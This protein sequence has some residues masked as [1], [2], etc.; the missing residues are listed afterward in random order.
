[1]P[2]N[3]T[4]FSRDGFGPPQFGFHVVPTRALSM[5]LQMDPFPKVLTACAPP[6]YGKTVMLSSL[7]DELTARGNTGLWLTLDDRD[8]DLSALLDR[9][10]A[11]MQQAGIA[12]VAQARAASARFPDR[13]AAADALLRLLVEPARPTI[14]F[15]DNLGFCHDPAL[16]SVLH[17][18]VF[19]TPAQ[20]RL[21]LSSTHEIPLDLA[22][23]KLEAG[24]LELRASH[25]SFDR[26]S[27]AELLRH[28]G[29]AHGGARQLDRIVAQTEGW[30]AAIR[31]L[32]VLL[33]GGVDA[34]GE[35][36]SAA[37]DID[38]VLGRFGGD[39]RD[40]ASVLT[41]R[42]LVGF[43]PDLVDFMVEIALVREFNADLAAE[44]TGRPEARQWLHQ[45]VES[46]VLI[47]PLDR[48]RRWFRF[49]TLL[50]EFLLAE[51]EQ[52]LAPARRNALLDRAAR[53]HLGQG[54]TTSAISIALEAGSTALAQEL[55]DRIAHVVVGHHGRMSQLIQW[56]DKLLA[57]GIA[58]SPEVHTWF[59][60]ALSDSLQYERARQALD[61]L[62]RRA[63]TDAA[64]Q[65]I[66]G[67]VQ[68]RI[69]F[70]RMLVN[71]W[72][73]RLDSAHE[74]ADVWLARDAN[75]DA[76]KVATVTSIAGIVDID[77]G[78]LSAARARMQLAEA[79]ISRA[80]S[81]YGL[82][83]VGI[84]RA[85]VDIGQARPNAASDLLVAT[86]ERAG[87]VIGPDASVLL[88]LDFVHARALLDQGRGDAARKLA[89]ASLQ[90]AMH[91][92]ILTTLEEGLAACVAFWKGGE[93][94]AG[95]ITA[96]L[97]DRVAHCYP[98]R[99]LLLLG[100]S[101][102]RRLLQLG[103]LAEARS[104]SE[105]IGLAAPERRAAGA[106]RMRERGDWLLARLELEAAQHCSS[107]LALQIEAS[108]KAARI[109]QRHR[110][111]VEL[112]LLSAG[113]H[114]RKGQ[115]HAAVRQLSA[116]IVLAAPGNLIHPFNTRSQL[117]ARLL[118]E[119]EARTI[120]LT[121]A[122]ELAFFER[123]RTFASA[124]TAMAPDR[125]VGRADE[126]TPREIE[127]LDLLDQGLN[128]EQ[129]AGRL[130]LSVATVKWHLHKLYAKLGV[131]SRSAALARARSLKLIGR[132]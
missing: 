96:D 1:M 21:V 48:S 110:D 16:G 122:A 7:F 51:G 127:L 76:L 22:R 12:G 93:D 65:N 9:L 66:S 52:T 70:T 101:K 71:V 53:W 49:H 99:G 14:L 120:G 44:M 90:R 40:I 2:V 114:Q 94:E 38:Q 132:A 29:I 55:L 72:L 130:H 131:R 95:G 62:D 87:C 79:A 10:G 13:G 77:R 42:V 4:D 88:T 31:L 15:I 36:A 61:D 109:D 45:L 125:G 23:A 37:A 47:F 41:R 63:A 68:Q 80:D 27:T 86:R 26:G 60:W 3:A 8:R 121:G 32:Q 117:I 119:D 75:A 57:A 105:R 11:A 18:L 28:A 81:A 100:A 107:E 64:F 104:L 85:C 123:L 20:L 97:L 19:G 59:V 124:P 50:R 58:P 84:L 78:T 118:S 30:P 103:R 25:L 54:D 106:E 67:G 56:V 46:N 39:H 5:A 111:A 113:V 126:P 108:I 91:H 74:Q 33:R 98:A 82:A 6:G 129:V 115:V 17:R 35:P 83:W 43:P 102:I 34:S 69:L 24:A 73:D 112:L 92:G 89:E 116:A 128:N